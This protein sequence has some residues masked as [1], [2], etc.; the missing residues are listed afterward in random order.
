MSSASSRMQHSCSTLRN[1][2]FSIS[3]LG[4]SG[5]SVDHHSRAYTHASPR[6]SACGNSRNGLLPQHVTDSAP[7]S[8]PR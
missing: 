8:L 2:W 5:E 7:V 1:V 4:A 3:S 6:S